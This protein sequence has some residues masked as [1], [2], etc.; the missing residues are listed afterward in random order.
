MRVQNSSDLP[1]PHTHGAE[2]GPTR[3]EFEEF[4]TGEAG[5]QSS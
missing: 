2:Y 3:T 1:G 5:G 4:C